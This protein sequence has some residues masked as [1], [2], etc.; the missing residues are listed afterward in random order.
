MFIIWNPSSFNYNF[1]IFLFE[2][3]H[4]LECNDR[5]E[6]DFASHKSVSEIICHIT[7]GNLGVTK[8]IRQVTKMILG[9]AKVILQV[10]KVILQVIKAIL[11]VI[12]A[13]SDFAIEL[14]FLESPKQL[15]KST[16]SKSPK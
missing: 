10:T 5:K 8:V 3:F 2:T 13:R 9:I 1:F 12:K 14:R 15:R 6:S 4:F 11:C 16:K 7:K